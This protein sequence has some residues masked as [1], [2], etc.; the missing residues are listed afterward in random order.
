MIGSVHLVSLSYITVDDVAEIVQELGRET[1]L[2]KMDIEAV[3]WLHPQDRIL[4]GMDWYGL[5][6]PLPSV[7]LTVSTKSIQRGGRCIV[8]V[9]SAGWHPVGHV[10]PR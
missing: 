8:L 6:R 1:L 10:L 5:C 9:P 4:Q 2:A 3:Y 7:W